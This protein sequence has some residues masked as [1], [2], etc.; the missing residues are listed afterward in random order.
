MLP[1]LPIRSRSAQEIQTVPVPVLSDLC[2]R[3]RV[4]ELS[5]F[6][7]VL[8]EGFSAESDVDVLVSFEESA[9]L[10]LVGFDRPSRRTPSVVRATG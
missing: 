8:R 5:L 1:V 10:E 7:S 3:W 4:R 2:Q 6:G 9:P